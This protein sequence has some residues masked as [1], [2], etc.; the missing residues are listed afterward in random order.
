M[1]EYS[2][3][4]NLLKAGKNTEGLGEL[5]KNKM[6]VTMQWISAAY[7]KIWGRHLHVYPRI[8][9]VLRLILFAPDSHSIQNGS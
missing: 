4:Y 7:I 3:G 2:Y 8:L 5:G 9:A 1:F 6:F